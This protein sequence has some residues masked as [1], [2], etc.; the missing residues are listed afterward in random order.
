[1]YKVLEIMSNC[2]PLEVLCKFLKEKDEDLQ[3]WQIISFYSI[4]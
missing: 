2:F 4:E 1:M 3:G